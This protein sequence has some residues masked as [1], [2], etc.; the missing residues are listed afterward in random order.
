MA[1]TRTV[2]SFHGTSFLDSLAGIE[3]IDGDVPAPVVP[4]RGRDLMRGV[5]VAVVVT[6]SAGDARSLRSAADRL[7]PMVHTVLVRVAHGARSSL[8]MAGANHMIE[9][10]ELSELPRLVFAAANR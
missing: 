9:I 5:S 2:P 4:A 1:G 7:G 10:G 8:S 3:T 6:G